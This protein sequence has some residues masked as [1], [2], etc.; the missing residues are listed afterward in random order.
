MKVN[1]A[2]TQSVQ[3]KDVAGSAGAK[4]SE[5]AG[6]GEA[7]S[8]VSAKSVDSSSARPEISAKAREFSKAQE[9]AAKA[10]D[11][12][13]EKIAELKKRIAAGNYQI[14]AQAIA[15]KM[16]DEHVSAGIG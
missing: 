11:I 13:E 10:P 1:S 6:S 4:R 12:R 9:A 5:K 15:D 14:N 8:K 2:T 7:A 16:V 3:N